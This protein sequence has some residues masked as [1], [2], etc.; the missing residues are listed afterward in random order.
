MTNTNPRDLIQRLSKRLEHLQ[1]YTP[2]YDLPSQSALINEADAYLDQPEPEG[3]TEEEILNLSEEHCVSYTRP[4]GDVIYPYKDGTDMKD[5]VL[6]F[7]RALIAADRARWGRPAVEPKP[8]SERPWE[9]EGWCD[10]E[11]RCWWGRPSG[12]LCNSDW[13]LAT[14]TEVKEFCDLCSP[15]VSL[16]YYALPVPTTKETP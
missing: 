6:S 16:P 10:A 11:W 3:L 4:G 5:D 9:R 1:F 2:V 15:T 13:F 12:E 8:V 14:R 7:A